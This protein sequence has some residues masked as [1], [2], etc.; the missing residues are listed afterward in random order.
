M[1]YLRSSPEIAYE[2]V[3]NRNNEEDVSI[4]LDY[5]NKLSLL[6]DEWLVNKIYPVPSPIIVVDADKDIDMINVQLMSKLLD[7]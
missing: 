3:R 1:I 5:L 2:R 6:H 7:I 4:T